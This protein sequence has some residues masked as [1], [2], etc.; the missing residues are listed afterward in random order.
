MEKNGRSF[1][2]PSF[3]SFTNSRN[4]FQLLR[5]NQVG[6][7]GTYTLSAISSPLWLEISTQCADVGT[8]GEICGIHGCGGFAYATLGAVEG[9]DSHGRELLLYPLL[10]NITG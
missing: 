2:L 1:L 9:D 4:W 7:I 6:T 5:Y 8:T 10:P 3:L